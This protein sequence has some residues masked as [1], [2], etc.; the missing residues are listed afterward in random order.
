[1]A[2]HPIELPP[3]QLVHELIV[4]CWVTLFQADPQTRLKATPC[5][6]FAVNDKNFLYL[7]HS[8]SAG[9]Y[10]SSPDYKVTFHLGG[11]GNMMLSTTSGLIWQSNSV[12]VGAVLTLTNK[13]NLVLTMPN[14][15]AVL[16]QTGTA[17]S[18]ATKFVILDDMTA[19]LQDDS[20]NTFWSTGTCI[21]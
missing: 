10:I 7:N 2:I 3:N 19:A 21:F 11:D 17:F 1:M 13:G 20:G 6:R 5:I 4:A 9:S 18:G 15:A 12:G 8:L 16:W 14:S